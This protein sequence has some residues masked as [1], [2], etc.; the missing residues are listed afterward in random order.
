MWIKCRCPQREDIVLKYMEDD[1]KFCVFSS[2]ENMQG[3]SDAKLVGC[4]NS[5]DGMA[6]FNFGSF[7]ENQNV[8]SVD[9]FYTL[10]YLAENF[11]FPKNL[12][13]FI[14]EADGLCKY[15][16][17]PPN[18]NTEIEDASLTLAKNTLESLKSQNSGCENIPGLLASIRNSLNQY[19]Q[20]SLP[21]MSD[22]SWYQVNDSRECF[23]LSSVNHLKE[24]DG[25]NVN[26]PWFFG[27]SADERVYAMAVEGEKGGV[28]PLSNADDCTV[29]YV[30]SSSDRAYFV[31]GIL[32]LDDGQYFC[33]TD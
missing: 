20:V 19:K 27:K 33:R 17:Y 7:S 26:L 21:L 24:S 10:S 1:G 9:K 12:S 8:L 18:I 31:V 29:S 2:F 5:A 22:F 4:F 15:T 13:H 16:F 30:S 25:F 3:Y 28:N 14:I 23:N 11:I 6:E 32:L